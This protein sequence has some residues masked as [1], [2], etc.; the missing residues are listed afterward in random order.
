MFILE[1]ALNLTPIL[2]VLATVDFFV[3]LGSYGV[4]RVL[5]ISVNWTTWVIGALIIVVSGL[6]CVSIIAP[7]QLSAFNV[8]SLLGIFAFLIAV[9]AAAQWTMRQW[10]VFIKKRTL[11]FV[12]TSSRSMLLFLRKHH[13]FFGWL[14]LI[15]ATAHAVSY[16][17]RLTTISQTELITGLIAWAILAYLIGFGIWIE[18]VVH[19][20]PSFK[21]AR[22]IHIITS[23]V[24]FVLLLT[25]M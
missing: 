24:F 3:L 25:H 18:Y 15:T 9:D 10:Y 20:R 16:L 7:Q 21:K 19:K 13:Q 6:T 14:V 4:L 11:P 1:R 2:F 22:L 8:G 5:H 12:V 17:P 23:I